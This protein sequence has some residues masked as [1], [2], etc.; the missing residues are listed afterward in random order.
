MNVVSLST[1]Q[2]E[3]ERSCS[4]SWQRY[5]ASAPAPRPLPS[6]PFT[7]LPYSPLPYFNSFNSCCSRTSSPR[8]PPPLHPPLPLPSP[9]LLLS[10]GLLSTQ[11]S[12]STISPTTDNGARHTSP[13]VERP[14]PGPGRRPVHVRDTTQ[15]Q[16]QEL[17]ARLQ[18]KSGTAL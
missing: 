13:S 7:L 15:S 1:N 5:I 17:L 10:P 16:A 2:G 18:D 12:R 14:P 9:T 11:R 6:P 8:P 4:R 3:E